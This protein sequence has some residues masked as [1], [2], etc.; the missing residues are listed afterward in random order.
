MKGIHMGIA[1]GITLFVFL[2]LSLFH[3]LFF[4]I[5]YD[6]SNPH[7][8]FDTKKEGAELPPFFT[9]DTQIERVA[10][11]SLRCWLFSLIPVIVFSILAG[12][13]RR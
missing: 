2:A 3:F 5:V 13:Y 10:K 9:N 4:L 7:R 12:Y 1:F 8:R 11:W 6:V